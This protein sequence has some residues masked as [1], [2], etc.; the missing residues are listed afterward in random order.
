MVSKGGNVSMKY[1]IMSDAHANPAALKKAYADA[2]EQK[3]EKFLFLGD[4]MGDGYDEKN[5]CRFPARQF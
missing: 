4:V 5:G 1:A 3:C 2:K